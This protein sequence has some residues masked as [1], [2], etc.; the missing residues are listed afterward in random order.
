MLKKLMHA[1]GCPGYM[2]NSL[3]PLPK[4]SQL[5]N[6]KVYFL[7]I[8]PMQTASITQTRSWDIDSPPLCSLICGYIIK[9]SCGTYQTEPSLFLS[10]GTK[11]ETKAHLICTLFRFQPNSSSCE[12]FI[13][14]MALTV[15]PECFE[16][17][18][19]SWLSEG[20]LL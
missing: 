18:L 8:S 19:I 11:K 16:V 2:V 5:N 9:L 10:L 6:P 3:F 13:V 4:P 17:S 1:W 14:F 15:I 7:S 12:S 20:S